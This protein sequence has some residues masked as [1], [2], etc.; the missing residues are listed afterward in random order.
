MSEPKDQATDTP[1]GSH[2]SLDLSPQ[3]QTELQAAIDAWIPWWR[4]PQS[5]DE[6][7]KLVEQ[8]ATFAASAIETHQNA[9]ES[10]MPQ[11]FIER[12]AKSKYQMVSKYRRTKR[13]AEIVR[14]WPTLSQEE[15]LLVMIKYG[16]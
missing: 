12:A 14:K 11:W 4:C 3:E 8:R 2:G 15:R 5:Q 10:R 13:R 1:R 6:W 9:V 16:W 7:D